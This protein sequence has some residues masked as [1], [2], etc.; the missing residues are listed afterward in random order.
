MSTSEHRDKSKD[1]QAN[2]AILTISDTRTLDNDSSGHLIA[3]LL[4][5]AGH[6][7]VDRALVKDEVTAIGSTLTR[8]LEDEDVQVILTTGGTGIA[9]RDTTIEVVKRMITKPLPGF[10]ELFRVLSY[11]HVGSAAMLSRAVAGLAGGTM[12]FTMPGS[13]NAVQLAMTKL[14]VPELAH[15]VWERQR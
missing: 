5:Q 2:C 15:M 10:G 14:I 8:W 4:E 13:Q 6:H 11:K 3:S 9:R 7:I 12:I 1:V